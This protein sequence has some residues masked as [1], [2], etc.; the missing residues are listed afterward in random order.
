MLTMEIFPNKH[1]LGALMDGR[2]VTENSCGI[3]YLV[4][5]LQYFHVVFCT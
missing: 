3:L 4:L 1:P 2:A 5:F